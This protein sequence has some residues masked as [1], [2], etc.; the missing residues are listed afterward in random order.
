MG[1]KALAD[2]P[3]RNP[4]PRLVP[5]NALWNARR[6]GIWSSRIKQEKKNETSNLAMLSK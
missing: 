5:Q 4:R 6:C 3:T 1:L 2:P